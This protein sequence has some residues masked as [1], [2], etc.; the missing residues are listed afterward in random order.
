MTAPATVLHKGDLPDDVT[1]GD[2]LAVD[3]E[4]LGLNPWRDRLCLLQIYDGQPGS[5]VH[6]VQF[7]KDSYDVPN[8]KKLLSDA[9]KKKIFY[10]ARGD[11]RW[12][13]QWLDVLLDNVYCVKV[14]S[15]LARTYT[16]SH[17]L[18]DS[19]QHVL[20][21]KMSKAQ[22]CTDWGVPELTAAQLEYAAA[23]VLYLHPL[24]EKLDEMLAREGRKELA[25]EAFGCIPTIV[26]LDLAGWIKED[27]FSYFVPSP[28]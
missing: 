19:L 9:S 3:S 15:R 25:D 4:F 18:E 11:M 10:F 24:M 16:Q 21:V 28:G 17:E 6:M 8:V 2:V 1:F 7:E 27:I 5:A 12:I 22:Q 26:K 20:G 14:A 23:D 13:K